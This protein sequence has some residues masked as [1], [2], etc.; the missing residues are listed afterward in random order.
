MKT[1]IDYEH[2]RP[3][4]ECLEYI[5]KAKEILEMNTSGQAVPY[6]RHIF[7]ACKLKNEEQDMVDEVTESINYYNPGPPSCWKD[8][9][10]L[11]YIYEYNWD[12]N[13]VCEV[14]TFHLYYFLEI[15][16]TFS[17]A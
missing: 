7:Y 12:Y 8:G 11:R 2:L 1:M 13:L 6:T 3:P 16:R 5:P 14:L 9:D 15:E 10:T 17:L 4:L